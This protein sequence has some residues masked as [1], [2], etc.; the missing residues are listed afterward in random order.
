MDEFHARA[1]QAARQ[2]E[3][4][5]I[6]LEIL[7]ET[8]A[9]VQYRRG[10]H[11]ARAAGEWIRTQAHI[12]MGIPTADLTERVWREFT[13]ARGRLS[14]PDSVGVAWCR[15]RSAPPLAFDSRILAHSRA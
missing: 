13:K 9:L 14:Y 1:I 5:V 12:E 2:P 8:L 4:L 7:A 6:P 10:F 11:D 15:T 3:G